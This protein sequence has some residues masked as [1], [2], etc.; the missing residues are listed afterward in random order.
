[1]V[2][3]MIRI[4]KFRLLLLNWLRLLPYEWCNVKIIADHL[5]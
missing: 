3:T 2:L 5:I 4:R 1:M